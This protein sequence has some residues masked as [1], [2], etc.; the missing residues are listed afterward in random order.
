MNSKIHLKTTIQSLT[1]VALALLGF[2]LLP[3]AQA[4]VPAPDGGYPNFTTAEGT[5]ALQHLTTGAANTGVGWA[6]LF[7]NTAASFNTGVGAATLAFNTGGGESNTAIGATALLFNTVGSSNTAVGVSA[8]QS[9]TEGGANTATGFQ[10]L[11]ANTTGTFNTANGGNALVANS[12]GVNNTGTG[13]G[14]LEFNTMGGNNTAMG[15]FALQDNTTG[16]GNT[17]VGSAALASNTTGG[18]NTALGSNAGSM[19]TTANNVICIGANVAGAN[20]NDSCFIGNIFNQTAAGGIAVFVNSNGKLGTAVSSRR[21]KENIQP[22]NDASEALFALTPVSFRY[23]KE[24]DPGGMQQFGLVAEDVEQVNPD[25]VVCDQ[26]GQ[27]HSVRYDQVNAMLLNEF[28]KEHRK[29]EKQEATI[30]QLKEQIEALVAHSKEQ[31]LQIQ[32]VHDRIQITN[33]EAQVTLSNQ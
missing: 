18:D 20:V 26:N 2:V 10:A 16:E 22:I 23:K 28:L 9:N 30:A 25:L 19:V 3:R 31:D 15:I 24:I 27:V 29:V 32:R 13:Y 5:N 4:V 12:T 17:A 6:S 21:F 8:L 33:L 7:S 11:F 1:R 14:A